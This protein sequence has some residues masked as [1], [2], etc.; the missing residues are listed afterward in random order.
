M[1]YIFLI[2]NKCVFCNVCLDCCPTHAIKKNIH[3]F[4]FIIDS[5]CFFCFNC[6]NICPVNAIDF[7][8][9]KNNVNIN[10]HVLK[11]RIYIKKTFKN[12]FFY[13]HFFLTKK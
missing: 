3:G 8:K 13:K 1:S 2:N 5:G 7:Y 9:T 6:V 12:N 10:K 4:Y 11:N